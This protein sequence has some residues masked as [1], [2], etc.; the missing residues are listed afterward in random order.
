MTKTFQIGLTYTDTAACDHG[1]V[2]SFTVV[3][4]TEKSIVVEHR[5]EK[6]RRSVKM[7]NGVEFCF[8]MGKFS[9]CPVITA[10]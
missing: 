2:Y 1:V 3:S 9:L 10:A 8:P 5:G 6:T 7:D 4:R